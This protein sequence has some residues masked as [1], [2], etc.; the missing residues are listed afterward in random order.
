[1]H[2]SAITRWPQTCHAN[3]NHGATLRL[4]AAGEVRN[5]PLEF[6]VRSVIGAGIPT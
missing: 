3:D 6:V 4:S 1:M 2:S 5:I